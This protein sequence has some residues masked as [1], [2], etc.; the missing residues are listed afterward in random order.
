MISSFIRGGGGWAAWC[1]SI[2]LIHN[3]TLNWTFLE[4]TISA[5]F[6]AGQN[7]TWINAAQFII[8]KC[9]KLRPHCPTHFYRWCGGGTGQPS[10]FGA[11]HS[12]GPSSGAGKRRSTPPPYYSVSF[13]LHSV[14]VPDH[15]ATAAR[16]FWWWWW[17]WGTWS[18]SSPFSAVRKQEQGVCLNIRGAK[19]HLQ[20]SSIASGRNSCSSRSHGWLGGWELRTEWGSSLALDSIHSNK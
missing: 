17:W 4:C 8:L 6:V 15:A 19:S 1:S 18:S 10:F 3:R 14:I 7:S 12:Y 20:L 11:H 2:N 16:S 5:L 13:R 9:R